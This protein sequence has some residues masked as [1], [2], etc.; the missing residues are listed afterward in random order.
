M[1]PP[2]FSEQLELAAVLTAVGCSRMFVETTLVKWGATPVIDDALL[3]VSELVTNSVKA[4]GVT[5]PDPNWAQLGKLN[6]IGVRL[7]GLERS[8]VI[9][10]WDIDPRT[11]VVQDADFDAES[12][13]GLF[14]VETVASRWGSRPAEPGKVVWAELPIQ[15]SPGE[16]FHE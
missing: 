7:L 10:V 15:P 5:T 13:R 11:P 6:L 2:R 1:P 8:I 16:S 12:G 3:V 14:L 4:T 9:E